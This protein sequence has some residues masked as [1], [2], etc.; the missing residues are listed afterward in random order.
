[1]NYP[2]CHDLL[3]RRLDGLAADEREPLE[4]HL[5]ACPHC[6]DWH[7][8][9]GLLEDGLEA[10]PPLVPPPGLADR[11]VTR[12]LAD[13][14]TRL[15]RRWWFLPLAAAACLLLT[16]LTL[17]FLGLLNAPESK[18]ANE[19]QRPVKVTAETN[20]SLERSVADAGAAMASLTDR[21]AGQTRD[22]ARLFLSATAPV[23]VPTAL[24]DRGSLQ[25]PFDPAAESLR[26]AGHGVSASL[27]PVAGSARRAVS[28]LVRELSPL[29]SGRSTID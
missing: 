6:R 21:I 8:A 15:R 16:P 28:Y 1:M 17:S 20:R 11:I 24:P 12:V 7:Q 27:E 5:A 3:H 9:A 29:D 10:L 26:Q 4:Q 14:R 23:E 13:R 25:A 19:Q 22:R 18:V 2:E